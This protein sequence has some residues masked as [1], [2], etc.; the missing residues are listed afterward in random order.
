MLSRGSL[1]H[2]NYVSRTNHIMHFMYP[3]LSEG[4]YFFY[5]FCTRVVFL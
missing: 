4:Q 1:V 5:V 2:A 3:V